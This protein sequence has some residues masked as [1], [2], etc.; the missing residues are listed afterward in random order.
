MDGGERLALRL[1]GRHAVGARCQEVL[2]ALL[3]FGVV[4][5]HLLQV[6]GT[7]GRHAR[8][9]HGEAAQVVVGDGDG[10]RVRLW[11]D[12]GQFGESGG[13]RIWLGA[14]ARVAPI[15][16]GIEVDVAEKVEVEGHG[17]GTQGERLHFPQFVVVAD[18][19]AGFGQA[20]WEHFS[21]GFLAGEQ[22]TRGT[23]LD[24]ASDGEFGIFVG[25]VANKFESLNVDS[26]RV[27]RFRDDFEDLAPQLT[28]D[29]YER[30]RLDD[31]AIHGCVV[32]Q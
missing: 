25:L 27:A 20:L 30:T 26:R 19:H 32:L 13:D 18:L 14:P 23:M 7:P 21:H 16:C 4:H 17:G 24:F 15:G 11:E 10:E 12:S 8:F 5:R 2:H 28:R 31:L 22:D 29:A 1:R 3:G 9:Y 6:G